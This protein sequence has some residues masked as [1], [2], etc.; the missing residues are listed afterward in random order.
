MTAENRGNFLTQELPKLKNTKGTANRVESPTKKSAV[1]IFREKHVKSASSLDNVEPEVN[2]EIDDPLISIKIPTPPL[3]FYNRPTTS[4]S[5]N[6][7]SKSD[8]P[9]SFYT[10]PLRRSP[11]IAEKD[12]PTTSASLEPFPEVQYAPMDAPNVIETNTTSNSNAL[13]SCLKPPGFASTKHKKVSFRDDDQ[14]VETRSFNSNQNDQEESPAM[15]KQPN[16]IQKRLLKEIETLILEEILQWD[17]KWFKMP[18]PPD[19]W[20]NTTMKTS[21]ESLEEYKNILKPLIRIEVL[22]KLE[23]SNIPSNSGKDFYPFVVASR[24]QTHGNCIRLSLT[25]QTKD[26]SSFSQG[27]ILILRMKDPTKASTEIDYFGY[28]LE[29]K[30]NDTNLIATVDIYTREFPQN[31]SVVKCK[32][33][34]YI[35]NEIKSMVAIENIQE[36]PLIERFLKPE[37]NSLQSSW[38]TD[39]NFETILDKDQKEIVNVITTECLSN[40]KNANIIVLNSKAGT[41]KTMVLIESLISIIACSK[42]DSGTKF[43]ILV[44]A[45][46]NVHIDSIAVKTS[47]HKTLNKMTASPSSKSQVTRKKEPIK[48]ARIGNREKMSHD[49]QKM[50]VPSS[51]YETL[52]NYDVIFTTVTNSYELY[53]YKKDFD[54][55][56][57][58][59]ANCCIDSELAILLQFNITKL[60]LIGDI[61]Q[62]QPLAHSPALLDSRYDETFFKK[63]VK[64]FERESRE[65]KPILELTSQHRMSKELNEIVDR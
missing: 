44:C 23:A 4:A 61:K 41:G 20:P 18:T 49:A 11:P 35:W 12:I 48:L 30:P 52:K 63:M 60:F 38:S 25:H 58:D 6:A 13:K 51:Q 42:R 22:A 14:L 8:P 34:M 10:E 1:E 47:Q 36:N 59:D 57:V 40:R 43:S 26:L 9:L 19:R 55:C 65:E 50:H 62:N 29:L 16:I 31:I 37:N 27:M 2:V 21:Y 5:A 32:P 64:V 56:F 28:V 3:D 54:V 24:Q 33:L 39:L 7:S 17:I 15:P 46:S 45:M 53:N